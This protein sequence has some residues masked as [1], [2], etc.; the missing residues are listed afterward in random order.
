MGLLL[1]VQIISKKWNKIL[2]ENRYKKYKNILTTP[3]RDAKKSYYG[4][5][6]KQRNNT[7]KETWKLLNIMINSRNNKS[8]PNCIPNNDKMITNNS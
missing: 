7:I 1:F 4:D 2:A 5:E 3:L 6:I 8:I